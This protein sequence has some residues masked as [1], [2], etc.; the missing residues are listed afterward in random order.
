MSQS[1]DWRSAIG[2]DSGS[3]SVKQTMINTVSPTARKSSGRTAD[4]VAA[5]V[6]EVSVQ[7][8][9]SLPA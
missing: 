8:M 7:W 1:H 2:G 6:A 4:E 9:Q 3:A 5:E